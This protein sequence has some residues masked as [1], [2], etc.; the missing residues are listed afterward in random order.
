[1][2]IQMG[3]VQI[4][5][6]WIHLGL[7]EGPQPIH[8]DP[9]YVGSCVSASPGLSVPGFC[10]WTSEVLPRLWAQGCCWGWASHPD[11]LPS[12]RLPETTL[13]DT[14]RWSSLRPW[15][16][17]KLRWLKS[18]FLDLADHG[19][20]SYKI[21]KKCVPVLGVRGRKWALADQA[22]GKQG[23]GSVSASERAGP[24]QRPSPIAHVFISHPRCARCC[25][26]TGHTQTRRRGICPY[27]G[28]RG[29]PGP[30][31]DTHGTQM[32]TRTAACDRGSGG[33][34]GALNVGVRE[35]LAEEVT[36]RLRYWGCEMT[37]LCQREQYGVF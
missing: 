13:R 15:L 37:H 36:S 8:S 20:W 7:V 19:L 35:H 32:S 34:R 33:E 12:E 11:F 27:L 30:A 10:T 5:T 21:L 18:M 25:P 4:R 24:G 23:P 26:Q 16:P 29:T 2:W 9:L 14:P 22:A 17:R 3:N 28:P 31:G 6:N 1:M